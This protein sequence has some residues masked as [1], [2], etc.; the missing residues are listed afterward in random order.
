MDWWA[1][2]IIHMRRKARR[3]EECIRRYRDPKAIPIPA[4]VNVTCLDFEIII[5]KIVLIF[6]RIDL[7]KLL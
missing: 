4:P 7:K 3:Q 6:I 2:E 5:R 1:F